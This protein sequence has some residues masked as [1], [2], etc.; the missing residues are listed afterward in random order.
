MAHLAMAFPCFDDLVDLEQPPIDTG[1][2]SVLAAFNIF[3][4]IIF[5]QCD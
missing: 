1:T 3:L 4:L 2:S 5:A